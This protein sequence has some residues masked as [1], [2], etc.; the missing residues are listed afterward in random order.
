MIVL[1]GLAGSGKGTQGN[2]LAEL[3]GWRWVSA[4][5]LIRNSGKFNDTVETGAMISDDEMIKLLL[6]E[7]ER[8]EAEGFDMVLDGFPRTVAQA[9]WLMTQTLHPIECGLI[10]EVP[11]ELLYE[12][13]ELRGRAD[14]TNKEHI[15]QRWAVFENN[16]DQIVKLFEEKGIP[17]RR[18]NGVG[19]VNEVT[20]RL[21][22]ATRQS[23][24]KANVQ[25]RDVN[26][27]GEVER[28]YGE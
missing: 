18:V 1:F 14:D 22:A 11:K 3:F 21:V 25:V 8:N 16:I 26:D 2:A 7:F 13:L 9:E 15:D 17:V 19:E 4:G 10:L 6:K 24:E 5:Q 20:A 23:T 28:S 12:R 27:G